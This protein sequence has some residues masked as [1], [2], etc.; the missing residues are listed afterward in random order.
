MN[1]PMNAIEVKK[2]ALV[3]IYHYYKTKKHGAT[4]NKKF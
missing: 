1:M 2:Q 4:C 3:T